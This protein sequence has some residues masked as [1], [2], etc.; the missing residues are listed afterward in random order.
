MGIAFILLSWL[1][2]RKWPDPLIDFGQQ[3]YVP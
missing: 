2:W 1:S 3:L